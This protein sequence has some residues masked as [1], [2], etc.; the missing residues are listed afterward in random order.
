MAIAWLIT[1]MS[2]LA[3]QLGGRRGRMMSGGRWAAGLAMVA[4]ATVLFGLLILVQ[5]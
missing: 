4:A 5:A 2:L 3:W 1:A